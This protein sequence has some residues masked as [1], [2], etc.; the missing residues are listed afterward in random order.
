MNF[1]LASEDYDE[2]IPV[3]FVVYS[4]E[5]PLLSPRQWRNQVH[6]MLFLQNTKE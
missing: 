2:F 6:I 3:I 1:Y 4:R 5:Q